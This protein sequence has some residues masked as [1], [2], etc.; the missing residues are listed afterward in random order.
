M[1]ITKKVNGYEVRI[2]NVP[3]NAKRYIIATDLKYIDD[4]TDE[5][6]YTLSFN[7]KDTAYEWLIRMNMKRDKQYH[8]YF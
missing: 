6:N 7:N 5:V 2:K 4:M 3:T 1:T 8:L